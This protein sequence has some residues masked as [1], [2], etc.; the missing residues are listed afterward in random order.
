[1]STAE[2]VAKKLSGGCA[3]LSS[4]GWWRARCPVHN[5]SGA[6]L[7]LKDGDSRLLVHCYARCAPED[8]HAELRRLELL[9]EAPVGGGEPLDPALAAR[10]REAQARNRQRRIAEALGFWDYETAA[11]EASAVERF[12]RAR[13]L[14]LPIP[15]TTGRHAVGCAILRAEHGQ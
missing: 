5:S 9:D 2:R 3:Y 11:A 13:G 8:I 7:A 6:T 12:W 15:P 14:E 1:M 10:R 4:G